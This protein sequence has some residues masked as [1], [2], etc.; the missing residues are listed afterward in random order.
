VHLLLS[1]NL[2]PSGE[3]SAL[4]VSQ[5]SD[6]TTADSQATLRNAI[7]LFEDRLAGWNTAHPVQSDLVNGLVR[8]EKLAT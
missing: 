2:V 6:G 4:S 3:R 7:H 5:P 1:G 8:L